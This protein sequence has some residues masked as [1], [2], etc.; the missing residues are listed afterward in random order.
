MTLS[1]EIEGPK[2]APVLVLGSSLGSDRH[3]WDDV[4]P[5]LK[6][7]RVLRYDFPG[8]G[9]STAEKLDEVATPDLLGAAILEAVD[10]EGIDQFH[11][12]GLSL[13]GMMSLWLTINH[14]ERVKSLIMMSSGS[15]ILPS[16]AWTQKAEN[17][18]KNGTESLVEDTLMRWFTP[19][20]LHE[21][22]PRVERTRKT[23]IDCDDEGYAQCCEVIS[24]LDNRPGLTSVKVPM[25]IIHAEYDGTLPPHEAKQLAAIIHN[26]GNENVQLHAVTDA[27]HQSA[28]ERPEQVVSG[29]LEHM[30]KYA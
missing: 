8:H 17:V 9:L 24:N 15:V 2:D 3:M 12:A 25:T 10:A 30:K 19:D 6:D 18:R 21:N 26:A 20:F 27:A 29:V 22:G 13:G 1:Y 28:V 23:F 7:Y 14:P 4:V 5:A 16:D 11:A